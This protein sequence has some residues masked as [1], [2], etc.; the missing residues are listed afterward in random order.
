M[1]V[2]RPGLAAMSSS[3]VPF[4][5]ELAFGMVIVIVGVAIA[6]G[7]RSI[8][9]INAEHKSDYRFRGGWLHI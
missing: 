6:L 5:A 4:Y 2:G 8:R 7:S 1:L 3:N 9:R